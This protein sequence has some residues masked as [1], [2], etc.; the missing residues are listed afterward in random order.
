MSDKKIE[1][2]Y[3]EY[4]ETGKNVLKDMWKLSKEDYEKGIEF[5]NKI[6]S[7][8]NKIEDLALEIIPDN[9]IYGYYV[10]LEYCLKKI[11]ENDKNLEM[12]FGIKE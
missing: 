5:I 9:K 11:K 3:E 6:I 10:I 1:M 8:E 4:K 12:G 7:Y 2:S